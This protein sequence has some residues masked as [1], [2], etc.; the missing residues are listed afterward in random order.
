MTVAIKK[1]TS[2]SPHAPSPPPIYWA[3]PS[4]VIAVQ[5]SRRG[6]NKPAW[7]HFFI[8]L[9]IVGTSYP[10]HQFLRK[11]EVAVFQ[12]MPFNDPFCDC[13]LN[14][15]AVALCRGRWACSQEACAPFLAFHPVRCL[16]LSSS[17]S[18]SF[19]SYLLYLPSLWMTNLL[20]LALFLLMLLRGIWGKLGLCG[21]VAPK[22]RSEGLQV[23]LGAH[24]KW[25]V[26]LIGPNV[27]RADGYLLICR[28][29]SKGIVGLGG[30]SL[31]GGNDI[32]R[33]RLAVLYLEEV[34]MILF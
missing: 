32:R 26:D 34:C 12:W 24:C 10:K 19:S 30:C 3:T 27:D 14:L 28:K 22:L 4:R 8:V 5:F 15:R 16:A 33:Q 31:V 23:G 17:L 1:Q 21:S 7:L 6:K 25:P 9:E 13:G 11:L 18:F 20:G 2:S 29:K